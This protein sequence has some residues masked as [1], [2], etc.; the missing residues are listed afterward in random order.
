MFVFDYEFI[1]NR[2]HPTGP[3]YYHP[4]NDML[5]EWLAE[6]WDHWQENPHRHPWFNN[7]FKGWLAKR[8]PPEILPR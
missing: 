6:E 3:R 1:L 7:K 5:K 2:N 8:A 4:P